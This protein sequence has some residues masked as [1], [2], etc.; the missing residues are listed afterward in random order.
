MNVVSFF[1]R[2]ELPPGR[3]EKTHIDQMI[4]FHAWVHRLY[5]SAKTPDLSFL[6]VEEEKSGRSHPMCSLSLTNFY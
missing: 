5:H 2:S 6:L 4:Y 1:V 3:I